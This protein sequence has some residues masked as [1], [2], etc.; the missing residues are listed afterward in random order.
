MKKCAEYPSYRL[1]N[2]GTLIKYVD[3]S[4]KQTGNIVKKN[5]TIFVTASEHNGIR[6]NY[7]VDE[8]KKLFVIECDEPDD[9]GTAGDEM[10]RCVN[11][12]EW[13]EVSSKGRVRSEGIIQNRK[14]FNAAGH[15]FMKCARRTADANNEYD[16]YS[17]TI[18]VE[19]IKFKYP[20]YESNKCRFLDDN[21]LNVCVE[22]L[23]DSRDAIHYYN[24]NIKKR[25][26]EG[27]YVKY[28]KD[29]IPLE[30]MIKIKYSEFE[31]LKDFNDKLNINS[32]K[33]INDLK[34]ENEY[35]RKE[36]ELY[37]LE[38]SI[39]SGSSIR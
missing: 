17:F 29:K 22:N 31:A 23:E 10:W 2:D 36:L 39:R 1:M 16:F 9:S 5:V 34:Q 6:K 3:F 28:A 4:K 37:R 18:W 35:L 25:R 24:L 26:A 20:D 12:R 13:L 27:N 21:K 7:D 15:P 33:E 19:V 38:Q 14:S 11:G 32:K 30:A 8:F